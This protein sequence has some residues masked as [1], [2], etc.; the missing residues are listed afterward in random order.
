MKNE[1]DVETLRYSPRGPSRPGGVGPNF[2][3]PPV[4]PS[5]PPVGPVRPPV[6]PSRPPFGTGP[7]FGPRPPVVVRPPVRPPVVG[8]YFG[9]PPFLPVVVGGVRFV[10]AAFATRISADLFG[11]RLGQTGVPSSVIPFVRGGLFGNTWGVRILQRDQFLAS[12]VLDSHI[13]PDFLGWF[14]D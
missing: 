14:L 6:G 3:R 9:R 13:I 4:G 11:L 10:V 7:Q 5:R 8:P 12:R 2:G 1:N